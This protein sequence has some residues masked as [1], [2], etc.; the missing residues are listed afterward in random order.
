MNIWN[1]INWWKILSFSVANL[2]RDMSDGPRM[3]PTPAGDNVLLTYL[4]KI[5][6]LSI[7]KSSYVW[8]EKPQQLS[9]ARK[10]HLQFTLSASL[11]S[12]CYLGR[13][14]PNVFL[15]PYLCSQNFILNITTCTEN[16]RIVSKKDAKKKTSTRNKENSNFC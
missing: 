12:A 14:F 15:S 7:S 2:P 3:S 8:L 13:Y 4:N 5:Y 10:W 1:C 9:I 6:T 11:I 16:I